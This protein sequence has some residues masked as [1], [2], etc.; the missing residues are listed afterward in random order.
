VIGA[1][2]IE[3]AEK[4]LAGSARTLV[5]AVGWNALFSRA[6]VDPEAFE[7]YLKF[8]LERMR[9]HASELDPRYDPVI[10]TTLRHAFLVG[11]ICGRNDE[12]D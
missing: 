8:H 4:Q 10:A 12:H 3:L 7:T 6:R 1:F 9:K 2:D 11:A 5:S